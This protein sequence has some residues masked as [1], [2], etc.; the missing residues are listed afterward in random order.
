MMCA[1]YFC[2][3]VLVL[4]QQLMLFVITVTSLV[5]LDEVTLTEIKLKCIYSIEIK[6]KRGYSIESY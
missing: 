1:I 5:E 6:L 2:E 3:V 4:R